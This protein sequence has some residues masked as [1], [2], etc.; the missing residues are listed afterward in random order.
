[1]IYLIDCLSKLRFTLNN[2]IKSFPKKYRTYC[3]QRALPKL[4][5]VDKPVKSIEGRLTGQRDVKLFGQFDKF[6]ADKNVFE[7]FE[8]STCVETSELQV[9]AV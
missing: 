7:D 8:L 1:M 9:D 5:D 6:F 4:C 3:R 2:L